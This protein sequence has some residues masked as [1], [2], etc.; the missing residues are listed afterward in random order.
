MTGSDI[1]DHTAHLLSS[2]C[3][4]R[5]YGRVAHPAR[6]K[7][8]P[9]PPPRTAEL[10]ATVARTAADFRANK[11]C[12]ISTFIGVSPTGPSSKRWMR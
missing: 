6:S 2:T 1:S 5:F 12:T 10:R 3:H 7:V 8:D 11:I 9:T 4:D